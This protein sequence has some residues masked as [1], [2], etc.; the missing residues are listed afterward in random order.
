MQPAAGR[1]R[2]R[3]PGSPPV[4]RSQSDAAGRGSDNPRS[5]TSGGKRQQKKKGPKDPKPATPKDPN[6]DISTPPPAEGPEKD[7]G[8]VEGGPGT[9]ASTNASSVNSP[10]VAHMDP[11]AKLFT[12]KTEVKPTGSDVSVDQGVDE[13]KNDADED[14]SG[15]NVNNDSKQ[16]TVVPSG[17]ED[18]DDA[19]NIESVA[20]AES[21]LT[22]PYGEKNL[23]NIMEKIA[24]IKPDHSKNKEL[25][26][27][28]TA[29]SPSKPTVTPSILQDL[30][31]M[32][33]P[34]ANASRN[35]SVVD[36]LHRPFPEVVRDLGANVPRRLSLGGQDE[37]WRQEEDEYTML[38]FAPALNTAADGG[39]RSKPRSTFDE[40]QKP[41]SRTEA[42]ANYNEERRQSM[43]DIRDLCEAA[44]IPLQDWR[45]AKGWKD[46]QYV[47]ALAQIWSQCQ[48]KMLDLLEGLV[49]ELVTKT[50]RQ[51]DEDQLVAI[52]ELKTTKDH[53]THVHEYVLRHKLDI[54]CKA[55][56]V[57]A[58][59]HHR[60]LSSCRSPEVAHMTRAWRDFYDLDVVPKSGNPAQDLAAVKRKAETLS[61]VLGNTV[62]PYGPEG[63]MLMAALMQ[64]KDPSVAAQ[65]SRAKYNEKT[66]EL[67]DTVVESTTGRVKGRE[68][69]EASTD[70][71]R[72]DLEELAND[73]TLE[74]GPKYDAEVE[75]IKKMMQALERKIGGGGVTGGSAGGGGS[76]SKS[77]SKK[78]KGIGDRNGTVFEIPTLT[79]DRQKRIEK[80]LKSTRPDGMYKL[81]VRKI[82]GEHQSHGSDGPLGKVAKWTKVRQGKGGRNDIFWLEGEIK[83]INDTTIRDL[84]DYQIAAIKV[85]NNDLSPEIKAERKKML[86]AYLE[87]KSRTG[88]GAKKASGDGADD[89]DPGDSSST[90]KPN[91][92]QDQDG[93]ETF[94]MRKDSDGNSYFLSRSTNAIVPVPTEY[95]DGTDGDGYSQPGGDSRMESLERKLADLADIMKSMKS[96]GGN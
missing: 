90:Q 23:H 33:E 11:N 86:D 60:L 41:A 78:V 40:R 52:Q 67:I 34:V 72:Q 43:A 84:N 12:P 46:S 1:G 47:Y 31:L 54:L 82:I 88:G 14:A 65:W 77:K 32:Y 79:D 59:F 7:T 10:M 76:K 62:S 42:I 50:Q 85:I 74:S 91:Q 96:A 64:S 24:N 49:T 25:V 80:M 45:S 35:Y 21:Y 94:E 4:T 51:L 58:D 87:K 26:A 57:G 36:L 95:V 5:A 71:A 63:L 73:K 48:Q 39:G 83:K 81:G 75:S 61:Q 70:S 53:L 93:K 29:V 56:S 9:V 37:A 2:G 69:I 18:E 15:D 92:T 55:H 17:R 20:S 89:G 44:G 16:D 13:H 68:E 27:D 30:E 22:G 19:M 66:T 38:G 28:L 8:S 6:Q 3:G